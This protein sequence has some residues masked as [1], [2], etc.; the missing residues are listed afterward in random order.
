[1]FRF[2][3]GTSAASYAHSRGL[4]M[5]P[6]DDL[7]SPK[8]LRSHR[9]YKQLLAG[10]PTAASVSRNSSHASFDTVGAVCLLNG[11][12]AAGVSSGGIAMKMSGRVGEA[13][14]YG[15]GC[16]AAELVAV[17]TSGMRCLLRISIV[18][19]AKSRYTSFCV[20]VSLAYSN[21]TLLLGGYLFCSRGRRA[22]SVLSTRF[23]GCTRV[24][25]CYFP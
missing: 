22:G 9:K 8:A 25:H 3:V 24:S 13:A 16:W 14:M 21:V 1:M 15:A 5:V 17:S 19:S 2:L 10:T 11:N 18:I 20:F 23:G 6:P 7:I 4:E 12:V